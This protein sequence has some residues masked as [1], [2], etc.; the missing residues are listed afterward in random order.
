M[1][2][3]AVVDRLAQCGAQLDCGAFDSCLANVFETL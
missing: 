3:D 1:W 2:S